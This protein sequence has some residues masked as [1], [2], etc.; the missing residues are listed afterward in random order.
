M[1]RH[2]G[3]LAVAAGMDDRRQTAEK[4]LFLELVDELMLEFIRHQVTAI[5]IRANAQGVLHIDEV[6]MADAVPE[7]FLVGHG[8]TAFLFRGLVP[9]TGLFRDGRRCRLG[10]LGIELLLAFQTVDFLA[11][12]HYIFF[13]LVVPGRIFCRYHTVLI[14]GRIQEGFRRIPEVLALLAQC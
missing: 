14:A 9:G 8:C 1:S 6:L 2:D 3:N 7:G 10:Q 4:V 12:I 13:H 5:C 11:Q